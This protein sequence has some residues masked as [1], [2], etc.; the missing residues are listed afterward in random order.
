MSPA[1]KKKKNKKD[2]E[3]SPFEIGVLVAATA[4]IAAVVAG[5]ILAGV[6][7]V[8]DGPDLKATVA[9]QG[10]ASGGVAYLVRVRNDGG[11]TAETVVVEVTVG[12]ETREAQIFAVARKDEE[13]AVVVFP[14]GTTGLAEAEIQS[15][16][17]PAR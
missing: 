2:S 3:R 12:E 9:R 6:Q 14:P 17:E 8:P 7:R 11:R 4:A 15:Y 16:A 13:S 5:L 1:K 10:E